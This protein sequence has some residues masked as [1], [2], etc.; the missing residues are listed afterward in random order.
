M[1]QAREQGKPEGQHASR[2]PLVLVVDDD[3]AIRALLAAFLE[4]EG[5]AVATAAHGAEALKRAAVRRPSV[6]V[7]DVRMPVMDGPTFVRR[8]RAEHPVPHAPVIAIAASRAGLDDATAAGVDAALPKPLDLEHLVAVVRGCAA[9]AAAA[10][11]NAGAASRHWGDGGG[12]AEGADG[13]PAA[14]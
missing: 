3:A 2:P 7:T 10:A 9:A 11:G 13:A 14:A 12:P 4:D 5:F 1:A 8:Y 6:I